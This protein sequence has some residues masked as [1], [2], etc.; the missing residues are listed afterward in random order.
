[1]G[2]L[3]AFIG[4]KWMRPLILVEIIGSFFT[5]IGKLVKDLESY[6]IVDQI[7]LLFQ[8]FE[9]APYFLILDNF[10]ILLRNGK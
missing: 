3:P 4:A 7:D 5:V 8:E 2:N 6:K 10:E 9:K 1:M